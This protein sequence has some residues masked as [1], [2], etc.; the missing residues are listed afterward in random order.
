MGLW[1]RGPWSSFLGSRA[2]IVFE[3]RRPIA[4][5]FNLGED[6]SQVIESFLGQGLQV[7]WRPSVQSL[8]FGSRDVLDHVP[9]EATREGGHAGQVG[10]REGLGFLLGGGRFPEL[11]PLSSRLLGDT[12]EVENPVSLGVGRGEDGR[13]LFGFIPRVDFDRFCLGT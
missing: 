7:T 6:P 5:C 13:R 9:Q 4:V 12:I 2:A 8:G 3:A 11:T 1:A 10:E